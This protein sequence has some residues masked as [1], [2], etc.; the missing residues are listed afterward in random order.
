MIHKLDILDYPNLRLLTLRQP[1]PAQLQVIEEHCFHHLEYLSLPKTSNFSFKIL[2]QFK[3]LRSCEVRSL[4]ID[5]KYSCS[6]SSIR[7]LILHNCHPSNLVYLLR[8]LPQMTFLKVNI[9]WTNTVVNQFDSTA[10]FVHP[11]LKS[12]STLRCSIWIFPAMEWMMIDLTLFQHCWPIYHLKNVFDVVWF[13]LICQTSIFNNFKIMY[14]NS[15]SFVS[16]VISSIC[17]SFIHC[18]TSIVFDNC[19]CSIDCNQSILFLTL[20]LYT[21]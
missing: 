15:N 13:Y 16:H 4:K 5:E 18:Q 8:H 11:N 21:A 10:V 14:W 3:S 17:W 2:C 6:S 19:H 9:Y 1:T 7:S 12:H 20:P